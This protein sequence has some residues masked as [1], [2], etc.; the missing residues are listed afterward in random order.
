[1][2]ADHVVSLQDLLRATKLPCT[3]TVAAAPNASEAVRQD[4]LEEAVLSK[5]CWYCTRLLCVL[6]MLDCSCQCMCMP[7]NR[8]P[9]AP[10]EVE[11]RCIAKIFK[12]K[13]RVRWG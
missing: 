1:M 8:A 13:G 7:I 5:R 10:V 12:N 2:G 11:G 3:I 9:T 4:L 6:H